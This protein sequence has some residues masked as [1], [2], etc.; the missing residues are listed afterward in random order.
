MVFLFQIYFGFGPSW[1][2]CPFWPFECLGQK[3]KQGLPIFFWLQ[4]TA[5]FYF[6]YSTYQAEQGR[7]Q[8]I[9]G[10]FRSKTNVFA[11]PPGT[12]K[13]APKLPF[14]GPIICTTCILL[15]SKIV[16]FCS[17]PRRQA[18]AC[19]CPVYS[20]QNSETK[21]F[22]TRKYCEYELVLRTKEDSMYSR[23]TNM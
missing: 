11:K 22:H 23:I 6:Q 17:R 8:Q 16:C 2:F 10:S 14:S 3:K 7:L 9:V 19:A 15:Q 21:Y 5:N 1:P 13:K 12:T 4:R 20:I 18:R